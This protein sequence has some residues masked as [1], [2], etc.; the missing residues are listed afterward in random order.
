MDAEALFKAENELERLSKLG[1][2]FKY[3]MAG[4]Q[5]I[6]ALAHNAVCYALIT[7]G[8]EGRNSIFVDACVYPFFK[9]YG[10]DEKKFLTYI[11]W[12]VKRSLFAP[13]FISKDAKK[14]W[15]RG[16]LFNAE[17]YPAYYIIGAATALRYISENPEIVDVWHLLRPYTSDN[18]AFVLA[19]HFKHFRVGEQVI[20]LVGQ[21]SSTNTNHIIPSPPTLN[22]RN[23]KFNRHGT[24]PMA[25]D[26]NYRGLGRIWGEAKYTTYFALLLC[27][28]KYSL[29]KSTNSFGKAISLTY[30]PLDDIKRVVKEVLELNSKPK[31]KPIG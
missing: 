29:S 25:K 21:C 15:K 14:I 10:R 11:N 4:P 8:A 7:K 6:S 22:I 17:K 30:Y 1:S 18:Q 3:S 27:Y 20:G 31:E 5:G 13:A 9:A 28:P 26:S 16:A 2:C 24:A 19:H 23:R 12:L